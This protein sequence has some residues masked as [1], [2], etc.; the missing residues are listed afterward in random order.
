M[1][2]LSTRESAQCFVGNFREEHETVCPYFQKLTS[3]GI[4]W[5]ALSAVVFREIK[6]C[7]GDVLCNS[8]ARWLSKRKV[9]DRFVL[10]TNEMHNFFSTGFCLLYMFRKNLVVH[11][12]EH[13][14]IYCITQYNRYNRAGKSNS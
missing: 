2:Y 10:M 14:I 9:L 4:Q 12:Q 5:S 13:G 3:W 11:H 1:L 7:Y 6:L 8:E